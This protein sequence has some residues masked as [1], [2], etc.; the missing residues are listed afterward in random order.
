MRGC[1]T[2][3]HNWTKLA[4]PCAACSH[5]DKGAR[6][7]F[8]VSLCMGPKII[9]AGIP[10][11][12]RAVSIFPFRSACVSYPSVLALDALEMVPARELRWMGSLKSVRAIRLKGIICRGTPVSGPSTRACQEKARTQKKRDKTNNN[13]KQNEEKGQ[14]IRKTKKRDKKI[15][16][17]KKRDKK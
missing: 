15:R 17:T 1:S 2:P 9:K 13:E 4:L 12:T 6:S 5:H 8:V 10:H 3:E 14:K 16:K 11:R 7:C